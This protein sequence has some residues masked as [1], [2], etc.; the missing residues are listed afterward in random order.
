MQKFTVI[1]IIIKTP[2]L[3]RFFVYYLRRK[4]LC[5]KM[6]IG[7]N[8][9]NQKRIGLDQILDHF[10]R[11]VKGSDRIADPFLTKGS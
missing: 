11:R 2:E 8:D 7:I 4:F 6:H 10:L 9:K 5:D 1:S 3:V